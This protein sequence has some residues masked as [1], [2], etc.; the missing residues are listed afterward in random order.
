M[1]EKLYLKNSYLTNFTAKVLE[2]LE[3][4]NKLFVKLD[5][6]AF[7]PESGGQPA[8]I[9]YLNEVKVTDVLEEGDDILHCIE[10]KIDLEDVVGT[11]DFDRRFEY[12]QQHNGQHILSQ[13]F[14]RTVGAQTISFHLGKDMCTIDLDKNIQSKTL[15]DAE[16]LA[17]LIIR[18][19]RPVK[20][21]FVNEE[22]LKKLNV[23]KPPVV[24]PPYRI[25]EI[26]EF[27]ISCC[28]GT[29]PRNTADV[30]VVKIFNAERMGNATRIYFKCGERA[31]KEISTRMNKLNEVCRLFQT[32]YI[33]LTE[34][35]EKFRTEATQ[36]RKKIS[37]LEEELNKYK[38][39][40]M[41]EKTIEKNG[42]R[43][44]CEYDAE[45]DE[46]RLTGL[47]NILLKSADKIC[48]VLGGGKED[49]YLIVFCTRGIEGNLKLKEVFTKA[50]NKMQG[51][52]GGQDWF[53]RGK[54]KGGSPDFIRDLLDQVKENV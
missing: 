4:D 54:G 52:G 7:Y 9:G 43:F 12:M 15:D 38:A 20:I 48:G 19:A 2:Y 44:V 18:E 10:K 26:E 22:E 35:I 6:T 11:V 33:E 17:N 34:L 21:K 14:L 1:T 37:K 31:L 39:K 8:D 45:A 49:F 16:S 24:N 51:K 42:I 46:K 29:H 25:V 41:I 53:L 3:G 13:A 27:D 47:A 5:K 23:R 30:Q 40:E 50:L 36:N 32:N 28:G